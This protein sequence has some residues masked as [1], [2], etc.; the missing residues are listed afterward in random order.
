MQINYADFFEAMGFP[1]KYYSPAEQQFDKDA[2]EDR[3]KEIID[4]WKDKYPKLEL[5]AD[6][7]NFQNLVDFNH[8][9]TNEVASLNFEG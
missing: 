3:I 4:K 1:Q 5:N 7:L 8:N 2:I 9:F 6:K